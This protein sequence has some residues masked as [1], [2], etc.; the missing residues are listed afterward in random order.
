MNIKVTS[1][2][3]VFD[4]RQRELKEFQHA[5]KALNGT[6]AAINFTA[7]PESVA[8]AIRQVEQAVDEKVAPYSD[9]GMV[10]KIG[11]EMKERYRNHI[12]ELAKSKV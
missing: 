11:D 3:G 5:M 2:G 7:A 6:V 9:N 8:A 12:L 10:V 4:K 1:S